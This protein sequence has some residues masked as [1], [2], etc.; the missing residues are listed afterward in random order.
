MV[1]R[2]LVC[3]QCAADVFSFLSLTRSFDI[4]RELPFTTDNS[5][6]DRDPCASSPEADHAPMRAHPHAPRSKPPFIC[7]RFRARTGSSAHA[8][9][10]GRYEYMHLTVYFQS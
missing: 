1:S 5:L 4:V 6:R 2:K 3:V 9:M 7:K 10:P 8:R